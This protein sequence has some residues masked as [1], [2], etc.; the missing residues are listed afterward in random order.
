MPWQHGRAM[1]SREVL[2]QPSAGRRLGRVANC[3]DNYNKGSRPL[4]SFFASAFNLSSFLILLLPP[5]PVRERRS[6]F[7]VRDGAVSIEMPLSERLPRNRECAQSATTA[8][9]PSVIMPTTDSDTARILLCFSPNS[10]LE[11]HADLIVAD[12]CTVTLIALFI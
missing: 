8:T 10:I 2:G 3:A 4:L 11:G 9:I 1:T 5:R 6:R 7:L 12:N